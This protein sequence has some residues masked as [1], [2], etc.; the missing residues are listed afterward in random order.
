MKNKRRDVQLGGLPKLLV[1]AFILAAFGAVIP[2]GFWWL[3]EKGKDVGKNIHELEQK[4]AAQ[5]SVCLHEDARWKEKLTTE[6]L[7]RA[8]EQ[9]GLGM[10]YPEARQIV[11]VNADGVPLPNQ[12]SLAS[13]QKVSRPEPITGNR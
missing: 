11:R 4:Y 12:S 2:L 6:N 1:R 10:G 13:L 3:D 7:D 5:E 9:H 8:I